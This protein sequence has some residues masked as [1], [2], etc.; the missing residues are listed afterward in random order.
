MKELQIEEAGD[1]ELQ[2]AV[3]EAKR[4][5]NMIKYKDEINNRPKAVW[6]KNEKQK[7]DIK[8]KSKQDLKN[9]SKKFDE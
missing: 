3:M 2:R 5:E 4:A 6:L 7:K 1:K 9:I 8:E